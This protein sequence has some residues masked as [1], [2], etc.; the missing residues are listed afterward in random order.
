[1][2]V[3]QI[4]EVKIELQKSKYG[5][6]LLYDGLSIINSDTRSIHS[7][8]IINLQNPALILAFIEGVLG[9]QMVFQN[10]SDS[11]WYFRREVRLMC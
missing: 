2:W 10:C 7:S 1:M 5:I 8:N 3:M 6:G 9:Y 4:P 11:Q